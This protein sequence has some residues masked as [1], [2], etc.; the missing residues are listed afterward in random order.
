[1]ALFFPPFWVNVECLLTH[2][3]VFLLTQSRSL[4]TMEREGEKERER[5]GGRGCLEKATVSTNTPLWVHLN[6]S[7]RADE[8]GKVGRKT[9]INFIK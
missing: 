6:C 7:Y 3:L 9:V 1:M 4:N 8:K 5:V 2:S